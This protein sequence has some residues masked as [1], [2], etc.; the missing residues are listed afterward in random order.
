MRRNPRKGL[1]EEKM[2]KAPTKMEEFH[3]TL[4]SITCSILYSIYFI[5]QVMTKTFLNQHRLFSRTSVI[6]G[7]KSQKI[8][9][10]AM[11]LIVHLL[12]ID[13]ME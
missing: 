8:F 13:L 2:W 10:S 9:I 5:L 12:G 3:S 6:S 11:A 7:P 1:K 4:C